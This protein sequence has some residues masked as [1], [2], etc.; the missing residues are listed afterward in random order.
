MEGNVWRPAHPT[1]TPERMEERRLAAA[2]LLCQ[3]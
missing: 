1:P 3:G 2:T